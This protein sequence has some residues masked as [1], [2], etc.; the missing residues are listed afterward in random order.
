ML[1]PRD[2]DDK[3]VRAFSM[4]L[5]RYSLRSDLTQPGA[6]NFLD[7]QKFHEWNHRAIADT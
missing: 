6:C 5:T 7:L 2:T 1:L 4:S 3:R